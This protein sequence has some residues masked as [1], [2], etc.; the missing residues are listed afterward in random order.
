MLSPGHLTK[1][2]LFS[3]EQC[4]GAGRVVG[5]LGVVSRAHVKI[6]GI[7]SSG[8][9]TT[10]SSGQAGFT[11]VHS[12][13]N[14]IRNK[15]LVFGSVKL[16]YSNLNFRPSGYLVCLLFWYFLGFFALLIFDSFFLYGCCKKKE[17]LKTNRPD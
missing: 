17:I 15:S 5:E 4:P 14:L 7:C 11:I 8:G 9:M 3:A 2:A 12:R 1:W 10:P 13:G 6:N 16:L